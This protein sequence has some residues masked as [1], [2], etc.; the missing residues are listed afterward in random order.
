MSSVIDKCVKCRKLYKGTSLQQMADLPS[1][2]VSHAA[3]FSFS[4]VD[5]FG[6]FCVKEGRK[7]LIRLG[8]LFT[9]LSC[10]AVHVEVA[11]SLTTDSFLQVYRRFVT[12]RGVSSFFAYG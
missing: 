9:C 11:N 2:R 8:V 4:G 3:T 7:V 10:R 12:V 1:D 5:F 6:P